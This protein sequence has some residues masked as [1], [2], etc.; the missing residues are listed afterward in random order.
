MKTEKKPHGYIK[1]MSR[2]MENTQKYYNKYNE[3][4]L[5]EIQNMCFAS[6]GVY[7]Q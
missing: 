2:Y 6:V 5:L 1:R 7:K 4:N 3:F